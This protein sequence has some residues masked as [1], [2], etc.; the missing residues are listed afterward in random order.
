MLKITRAPWTQ[1]PPLA[2]LDGEKMKWIDEPRTDKS[3]CALLIHP[4]RYVATELLC[5]FPTLETCPPGTLLPVDLL[6][7]RTRMKNMY[8][9]CQTRSGANPGPDG[10]TSHDSPLLDSLLEG[11]VTSSAVVR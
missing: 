9:D 11:P 6:L 10:Y 5:S 7:G 2:I 3:A 1:R 8:K 4:L